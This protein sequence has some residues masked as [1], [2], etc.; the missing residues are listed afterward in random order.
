MA[1]KV[2]LT[3]KEAKFVDEYM[4]DL[5]ATGAARRAGYSEKIASVVG[6]R[7][8]RKDKIQDALTAAR[9]ALLK[10]TGVTPERIIRERARLAF[11]DIG[12]CFDENG[13]LLPIHEIPEDTRRALS[14]IEI[15]D[16]YAGAG[17]D[18]VQIGYTKK[19]KTWDKNRA[20]EALEKQFGLYDADRANQSG[21]V[22]NL[23]INVA[24]VNNGG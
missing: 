11:A 22:I 23:N 16:L 18:R 24:Q 7:L 13:N 3:P 14:G 1:K 8:L 5:N 9:Q 12:E 2:K 15:E 10:K 17:N 20:L 4:L 21:L 19:V 6:F